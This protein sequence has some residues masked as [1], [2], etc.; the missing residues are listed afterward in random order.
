[1]SFYLL[2]SLN[3]KK[4]RTYI[5]MESTQPASMLRYFVFTTYKLINKCNVIFELHLFL[6]PENHCWNWWNNN[7]ENQIILHVNSPSFENSNVYTCVY[8]FQPRKIKAANELTRL[9]FK[10]YAA[11]WRRLA[12]CLR[13]WTALRRPLRGRVLAERKDGGSLFSISLALA[14]R[15]RGTSRFNATLRSIPRESWHAA[16]HV[17]QSQPW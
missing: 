17:H 3:I 10:V 12:E 8:T 5:K 14:T 2:Y 6:I 9:K 16:P 11:H 1:M 13:R 15:R 7:M 4:D